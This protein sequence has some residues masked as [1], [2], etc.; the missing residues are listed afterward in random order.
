MRWLRCGIGAVLCTAGLAHG[1]AQDVSDEAARAAWSKLSN[2]DRVEIARWFSAECERLDTFQNALLKHVFATLQRAR[3][4][5]PEARD[6]LPLYDPKVHAPAQPIPRRL[7]RES[8]REVQRWKDRVYAG[9]PKR[10]LVSGWRYDYAARSV[11]RTGEEFDPERIFE[12]GL[13]GL[14]PDLDLAEAVVERALDDGSLREVHAAFGHG[15][16]DRY[17]KAYPGVS[18]YD[19]W[20]SG[21]EMEMPDV[22]CLGIV[23]D[24]FDDWK[25]WVAPVPPAKHEALYGRLGEQFAQARR[26]RGLRTAL[27]RSYLIGL[28]VMRDGYGPSTDRLH[29]LW[30]RSSSDPAALLDDLP[31]P[32]DD[33]LDWWEATSR[34][35][36]EDPKALRAGQVRRAT[37]V[38]DSER[39]RR[40][41]IGVMREYGALDG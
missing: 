14:P 5:W 35:V 41:L 25:T 27:A 13:A 4:D 39:V 30:D 8:S 29:S 11:V 40:V 24:L 10:A 28:P 38:A 3:Y 31:D 9:V 33:W 2:E 23:H 22:E 19:V 37:L 6:E 17:G 15:Y 26:H 32:E 16:A 36:D 34:K 20:C 7:L 1:S 12:S 18:L 21:A